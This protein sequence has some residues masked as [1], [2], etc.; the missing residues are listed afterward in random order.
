MRTLFGGW[1]LVALASLEARADDWPMAGGDLRRSGYTPQDLPAKLSLRWTYH[2]P[3][4]PMPAW[5]VSSRLGFDRAYVPV[6]AGGLLFFGSSADGKLY[7]LD[8]ATGQ[9]RWSFFTGGPVRFAPVAWKDRL[10]AVSDDGHLYCLKAA[11]GRLLW[12]KRGGPAD[13]WV[14]GNDR[15][16]SHWPARGGPVVADDTVYFAAGLWPSDGIY[17]YALDADSGQLRWCNDQ[18][19]SITMAQPHGGAN[20]ESG[21]AAQGPLVVAGDLLLVPTGRAVPAAFQRS[22]GA[23]KYFH[24]QQNGQKGGATTMSVGP[25]FINGGLLFDVATG[26]ALETV[27][28]GAFAASPDGVIRS[29]EKDLSVLRIIDKQKV[30]RKGEPITVKSLEKAWSLPNVPGGNAVIAAGRS[31]VTGGPNQVSLVDAAA[32]KAVWSAPV[33]GAPVAL[34]AADGRLYVSTDKGIVSCFA[35]GAEKPVVHRTEPQKSPYGEN[36]IYAAAAQAILDKAG[37]SEGYAVDLACGDGALAFELARRSK[38]QVIA[39]DADPGNVVLA[40]RKLDSAGLYGVRVV[41]H[42]GDPA[43]FPLPKSFAA[44]VV[45]GR[46]VTEG[47]AAAAPDAILRVQRPYGGVACIGR[48][49][50]LQKTVRGALEGAGSWTHQYADPANTSCSADELVRG[51]LTLYWFRESD[52]EMPQRHG[53]GPAPLFFEGR[54]FVE[55]LNGI[56][57][58]DA[59]SGR[60]L[61]DFALPKILKPFD[62]EHLMG[63]AG[64]GSNLCVSAD[65]VYVRTGSRCLRL[66]PA[67]GKKLGEFEAPALPGGKAG[68]WGYLACEKGL[69]FGSLVNEEHLVKWRYGKSDMSEQFTE[70]VSLFAMDALTGKIQWTHPAKHSFRH[71]AIAI[72]GGRVFLIDR[73]VAEMDRIAADDKK[74][75]EQPKGELR[76]LDAATGRVSWT[77]PQDGFG[78]MLVAGVRHDALLMAYQSTRFK[79]PSEKGG[80]LAVLRLSDGKRLWDKKAA[81]ASRPVLVDRTIYA[82]GGA[83]DL[84]T[85]EEQKFD[86]KRSHGCGQLAC[87]AHLAV[88]RSATMGYHDFS[89]AEATSSYGGIR[90]G[91][92]INAIPAGGLVLAPDATTGCTC[93]YLNQAWIALQPRD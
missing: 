82:Q 90:L 14:L 77:S 23:F 69:L 36:S 41:V 70:S 37:V 20:A 25:V 49:D 38:L 65:G 16:I 61:W 32:Q 11:D 26:A 58:A 8:A 43:R 39:V 59:Y 64:T 4:A 10:F 60:P 92:W 52:F 35:A 84:L 29:T 5:P 1:L 85:G 7:A 2:A 21:V 24:L 87:S 18:S 86:L 9:E 44:L 74:P 75:V 62:G 27:G 78:T 88:Y 22:D 51:P 53:R 17:L 13:R 12:K 42:A 76:A 72:G 57:A 28:P 30:D 33:D 6:L 40:R 80:E 47:A 68:I 46:S 67:T 81:Y 91:C 73:P 56:R 63:T 79:L 50:A 66:D 93:S 48:P 71:N 34:A 19:G 54:L 45:S 83:W 3:Q 55:G 31:I 89:S 15:L